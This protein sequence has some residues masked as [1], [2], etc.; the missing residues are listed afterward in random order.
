MALVVTRQKYDR[1]TSDGATAYRRR[2]LS[3]RTGNCFLPRVLQPGQ[4]VNAGPADDPKNSLRHASPLTRC[5][6]PFTCGSLHPRVFRSEVAT[7]LR[8]ENASSLADPRAS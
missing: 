2:G 6:G 7:V 8:P 4:I 1:Q 3:P 5:P